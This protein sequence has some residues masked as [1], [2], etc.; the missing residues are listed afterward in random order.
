MEN[1]KELLINVLVAAI[2]NTRKEPGLSLEEISQ[3]IVNNLE[4]EETQ[5]LA[6]ELQKRIM[7]Q[8]PLF[9]C[10]WCEKDL[11]EEEF[12]EHMGICQ[13]CLDRELEEEIN[14]DLVNDN[15]PLPDNQTSDL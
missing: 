11:T 2:Q 1:H 3:A 6:I 7:E 4:I 14:T 12:G 13:Q 9:I 5:S 15:K 10:Q 8:H